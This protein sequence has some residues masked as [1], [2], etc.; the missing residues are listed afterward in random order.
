MKNYYLTIIVS[1]CY[2]VANAQDPHF[3]QFYA[4]PLTLNPALTGV[5]NYKIQANVQYRNQWQ[6]VTIP[7]QTTAAS[8]SGM[9][10]KDN[11][12]LGD[13]YVGLGMSVINNESGDVQFRNPQA[14]LYAAYH[15]SLDGDAQHFLSG[16]FTYG[17]GQRAINGGLLTFNSQFDGSIFNSNIPSGEML[18]SESITY[19][20]FG[21]GIA[22][23]FTYDAQSSFYVGGALTH[24]N[25]PNISFLPNEYEDPLD[26]KFTLYSG[27]S[28]PINDKFT[29]LFQGIILRQGGFNEINLGAFV[30]YNLVSTYYGS[31]ESDISVVF[32]TTHRVGDA[33]VAVV[34]FDIYNFMIGFSYDANISE[35]RAASQTI[36]G[37]ELSVGYQFGEVQQGR[38]GCPVW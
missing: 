6:S 31:S 18:G 30:R 5:S 2:L 20:D 33:Q 24:I 4:M 21:A 17:V 11:G 13:D 29:M 14:M 22:Y 7:F 26:R 32:G 36:G 28:L 34:R 8:L 23:S 16:G 12:L 10:F 3:S 15:K 9:L 19:Q 25:T 1:L 38:S 37:F 27:G 35:L